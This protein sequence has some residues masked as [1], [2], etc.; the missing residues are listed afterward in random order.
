MTGGG[1]VH[2]G[3][4]AEIGVVFIRGAGQ[5][6]QAA[7]AEHFVLQR[8][9]MDIL[10]GGRDPAELGLDLLEQFPV[11]DGG[12]VVWYL[13]PLALVLHADPMAADLGHLPLAHD[14]G[15]SV[16]LVLQD[17]GHS[18][19]VPDAPAPG[20]IVAGEA[21]GRLVLCWSRDAPLK[22]GLGDFFLAETTL[23]KLEYQPDIGRRLPI[24]LHAPIG[25]LAIAI[26]AW[27]SCI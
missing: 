9:G 3:M 16:P 21:V 13:H 15:S 7:A 11:D 1:F 17:V 12:M 25:S 19:L 18:G 4:T 8:I 23:G 5:G 27:R 14:V 20:D 10:P 22:Q 24:R 2:L 26:G 6:V